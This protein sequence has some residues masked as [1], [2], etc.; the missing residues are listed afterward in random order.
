MRDI[1][2]EH[3]SMVGAG[4]KRLTEAQETLS[5]DRNKVTICI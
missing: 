1:L 3:Q 2:E 4:E 5:T